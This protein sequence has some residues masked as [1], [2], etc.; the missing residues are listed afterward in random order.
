M[1]DSEVINNWD[2]GFKNFWREWI[3]LII[4]MIKEY[5]M[6]YGWEDWWNQIV[7]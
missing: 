6:Q 3:S 5:Q 2:N 1:L 7:F 4:G